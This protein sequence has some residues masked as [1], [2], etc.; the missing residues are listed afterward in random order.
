MIKVLTTALFLILGTALV[1]GIGFQESEQAIS[2]NM[3]DFFPNG[4]KGV[5]WA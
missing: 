2:R 4:W 5:G 1:L 3:E